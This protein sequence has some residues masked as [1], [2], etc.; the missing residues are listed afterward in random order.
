MVALRE[1]PLQ[2]GRDGGFF[3]FTWS[4]TAAPVKAGLQA[5]VS[6][7]KASKAGIKG[8]RQVFDAC[9]TPDTKVSW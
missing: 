8:L 9:L 5:D 7:S 2:L 1:H 6:K 3:L 4:G